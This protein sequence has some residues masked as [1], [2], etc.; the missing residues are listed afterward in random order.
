MK[1][2][3]ENERIYCIKKYVG[4]RYVRLKMRKEADREIGI[5]EDITT[6]Y[7]ERQRIEHERDFDV[8]QDYIIVFSFPKTHGLSI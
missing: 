8:L 1:L 7:L 5:A 2:K 3:N 6:N 4:L